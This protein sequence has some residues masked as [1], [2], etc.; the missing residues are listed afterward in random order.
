[1]RKKDNF[2]RRD[3]AKALSGMIGLSLEE[4][5]V[6]NTILDL[7]YTT[8]R[9]LEDDRRFIA[10]WCGC[11]VQKINPI[12]ERLI[13]RGRLITFDEAGRTYL[14]DE[15]F[16][17]EREAV[18]GA[19]KAPKSKGVGEKSGEVGEKSGGVEENS[20]LLEGEIQQ[21]Q[22]DTDAEKRRGEERRESGDADASP[23]AASPRP[24]GPPVREAFDLYNQLAQQ[25]GLPVA[26]LLD[27]GRRKAIATRL[28]A[29]G[30][31]G[32]TAALAALA[33]SRHCRGDNDRR[34]KADLDFVCQA[35]SFRRLLEGF[36]GDDAEPPNPSGGAPTWAG[37]S[38]IVDVLPVELVGY[39][40][41]F[42]WRELP[43]RSLVTSSPTSFARLRVA[44]DALR[45]A[46]W[47]LVLESGEAA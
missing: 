4:R 20:S 41:Y 29:D 26:K 9:P 35:K 1:M 43:E 25:I 47:R 11:A 37:P 17:A 3:P 21:K 42:T 18:K 36:Y 31:E 30:I 12:I 15:A 38:E 44:E 46:G 23:V 13:E 2:Y 7:L 10:N 24:K 28:K 34:W 6:Y 16:E 27:E 5:G 39:L 33:K 32:W 14:S 45:R 22:Y 8:W 40:A 19:A